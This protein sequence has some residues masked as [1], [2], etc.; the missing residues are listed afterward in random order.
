MAGN[1]YYVA[2]EAPY[3]V[4]SPFLIQLMTEKHLGRNALA[5]MAVLAM[6]VHSDRTFGLKS[7]AK[8]SELSGLSERA[9]ARGMDELKANN[10]ITPVVKKRKDGSK[11]ID[12]SCFGHV[13][14][15]CF[16]KDA[17]E[18]ISPGFKQS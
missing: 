17:W 8:I 6:E 18:R 2:Y 15:Y 11:Y 10:L 1:N 3:S 9:V 7:A 14:T 4:F 16:T 12:R 5:V 13:A